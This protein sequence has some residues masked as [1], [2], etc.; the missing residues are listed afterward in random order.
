MET[1]CPPSYCAQVQ[2]LP[3]KHCGNNREGKLFSSQA[4]GIYGIHNQ[5][6]FRSTNHSFL[7]IFRL[8]PLSILFI[9]SN[10][11][12]IININERDHYKKEVINS[13]YKFEF[14]SHN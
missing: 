7:K 4:Y 1:M 11:Q 12:V 5:R 6:I 13:F 9:N 3:Q 14:T 10:L 2:E 8:P